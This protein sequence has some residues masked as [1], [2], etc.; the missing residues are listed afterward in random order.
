MKRIILLLVCCIGL[1]AGC[2]AIPYSTTTLS[3]Y[4][5]WCVPEIN[6]VSTCYIGESVIHEEKTWK[7]DSICVLTDKPVNL[8]GSIPPLTGHYYYTGTRKIPVQ[9]DNKQVEVRCYFQKSH[10]YYQP[11]YGMML[12]YNEQTGECRPHCWIEPVRYLEK[13][14]FKRETVTDREKNAFEKHLL[15]TG[16][17]GNILKFSYR[18]FIDDLARP[19]FTVD[20][21]YDLSKD[22]IIRFKGCALEI[23]EY[24]NQKLKYRLLS[25][26]ETQN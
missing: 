6:T 19:A 20:V 25:G 1:F 23:L 22:N 4:T 7:T 24:D 9:P 11:Y 12:Y 8:K 10:R 26:F 14:E 13:N 15:F 18:E 3:T 2:V 5:E 16:L 21:T 17:E